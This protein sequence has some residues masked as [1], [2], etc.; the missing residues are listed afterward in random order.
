M[1]AEIAA[2]VTRQDTLFD[3]SKHCAA[4]NHLSEG[5]TEGKVRAVTA[6]RKEEW[7]EVKS[8]G[9]TRKSSRSLTT[10]Y[11]FLKRAQ[12]A[13]EVGQQARRAFAVDDRSGAAGAGP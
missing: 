11:C 5:E 7:L 12:D 10:S 6:T 3:A 1:D 9:T 8:Q 13:K 2:T 4:P